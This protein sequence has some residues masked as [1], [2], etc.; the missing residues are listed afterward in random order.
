MLSL[1]IELVKY[2]MDFTK[3]TISQEL[4]KE[5]LLKIGIRTSVFSFSIL[6]IEC[7]Q[8][9]RKFKNQIKI[10]QGIHD[11]ED[12]SDIIFNNGILILRINDPEMFYVMEQLVRQNIIDNNNNILNNPNGKVINLGGIKLN[13]IID[14]FEH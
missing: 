3:P 5:L 12:I 7:Q 13:C 2:I 10:I 6:G 14:L 8:I 4:K 1:P 9:V 11:I